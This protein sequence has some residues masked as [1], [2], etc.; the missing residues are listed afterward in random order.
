[1][2]R[3][4]AAF[5]LI[6]LLVV[7][8]I[9]AILMAL[10]MPALAKSRAQAIH[11]KCLA[12]HKQI[13][14][15]CIMY[16]H[17]NDDFFPFVT[18]RNDTNGPTAGDPPYPWYSN[19]YAGLYLNNFYNGNNPLLLSTRSFF[20]PAMPPMRAPSAP[21]FWMGNLGIGANAVD[22]YT[23]ESNV[24]FF[25]TGTT[26][27][28]PTKYSQV[29][30]PAR[31]V[32]LADVNAQAN[33]VIDDKAASYQWSFWYVGATTADRS[34]AYRHGQR[35]TASFADGHVEAFSSSQADSTAPN[36]HRYQGLHK[37]FLNGSVTNYANK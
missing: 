13:V 37:A 27:I 19:R 25:R 28:R 24:F 4:R 3:R 32:V 22:P 7:V 18:Y 31:M 9:I 17:E 5:T 29:A 12:N 34:V 20:C 26:T 36:T 8:A 10:L 6:E 35:T 1:M 16:A 21:G 30:S 11:A 2:K 23:P 14:A 33:G 15:A